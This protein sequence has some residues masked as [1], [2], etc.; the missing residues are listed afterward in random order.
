MLLVKISTRLR[1]A[2]RD[3]VTAEWFGFGKGLRSLDGFRVVEMGPLISL[4]S[5]FCPK[6]SL[7][8]SWGRISVAFLRGEL[9]PSAAYLPL[10]VNVTWEFLPLAS[11]CWILINSLFTFTSR[12]FVSEVWGAELTCCVF[13]LEFCVWSAIGVSEFFYPPFSRK[14]WLLIILR[15]F[16]LPLTFLSVKSPYT[17]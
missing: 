13:Y 2:L 15:L 17:A 14:L 11:F 4:I 5:L 1:L 6:A 16:G 9:S 10:L 8:S 7:L 3:E 12:V